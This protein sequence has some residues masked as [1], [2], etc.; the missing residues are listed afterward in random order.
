MSKYVLNEDTAMILDGEV[1]VLAREKVVTKNSVCEQCS[2]SDVCIDDGE[3]HRLSV[4][5]MPNEE[6]GRWFFLR[7]LIYT[8]KGGKDLVRIIKKGFIH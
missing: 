2:L 4:L 7:H 5:C 6:D 8:E 3:N 1:Y